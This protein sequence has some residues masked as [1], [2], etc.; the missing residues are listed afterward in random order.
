MRTCASPAARLRTASIRCLRVHDAEDEERW[1]EA[2]AAGGAIETLVSLREEGKIAHVSLGFNTVEYLLR[3]L[4]RF[5]DG[6]FDNI[7]VA[8]TWNLLDTSAYGLLAECQSRGVKV[9][10]AAVF[11]SGLLWGREAFMYSAEVPAEMAAKAQRWKEFSASRGFPLPAVALAFAY[12]PACVE[13]VAFGATSADEVAANVDLCRYDIPADFWREA[14]QQGLL[15]DYL[16][17]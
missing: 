5:P 7:M 13:H 17:L 1:A 14:Q 6:T 12:L 11:C 9:H 10:M 3:S 8:R 2:T 15:P 16:A 4:R